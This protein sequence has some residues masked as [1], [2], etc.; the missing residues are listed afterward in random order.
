MGHVFLVFDFVA[1]CLKKKHLG[2]R[3][4]TDVSG[5]VLSRGYFTQLTRFD[6]VHVR[7]QVGKPRVF[8]GLVMAGQPTPLTY[9]PQK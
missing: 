4:Q 6:H 8:S 5:G 2:G 9:P 3:T 7:H 1:W